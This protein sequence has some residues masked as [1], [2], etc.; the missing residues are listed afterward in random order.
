MIRVAVARSSIR[1][2]SF[3]A[4]ASQSSRAAPRVV[5]GTR[6]AART[7]GTSA[8][9]PTST[10]SSSATGR[11]RPRPRRRT[12]TTT[13]WSTGDHQA[14]S[15][16]RCDDLDVAEP[17]IV[18]MPSQRRH[19]V[20]GALLRARSGCPCGRAPR[21]GSR[22][23]ACDSMWP[24]HR[25]CRLRV[26]SKA[27]TSAAAIPSRPRGEPVDAL[28]LAHVVEVP[29]VARRDDRALGVG[30]GDDAGIQALD[31]RPALGVPQRR[32][33][34]DHA[35]PRVRQQR[36]H[37]RVRVDRHRPQVEVEDDDPLAAGRDP[38]LAAHVERCRPRSA[39]A[40]ASR[41]S[42][43]RSSR[44]SSGAA[45]R[46]PPGPRR[47]SGRGRA[48]ARSPRAT[49]RPP[50]RAAG[51]RPCCRWRRG[52]RRGRRG[53]RARRAASSTARAGEAGCTS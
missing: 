40:S 22:S 50:R 26:G 30:R 4:W 11:S 13:G 20:G 14:G 12:A 47:G 31:G 1:T 16:S 28:V 24:D 46:S 33:R 10:P 53:S 9:C 3:G 15:P 7:P 8:P 36:R 38:R 39:R 32:E 52:P 49:P 17:V 2:F 5:S 18:E 27:S 6:C 51:T 29:E 34:G 43:R 35:L 44:A 21:P 23:S 41:S 42:G 19:D 48:A 37:A 25:P 45:A